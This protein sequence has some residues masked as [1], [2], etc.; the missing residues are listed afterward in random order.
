MSAS[1]IHFQNAVQVVGSVP[2]Q[3]LKLDVTRT[4]RVRL[5]YP[6]I[7]GASLSP[8]AWSS[9]TI[10]SLLQSYTAKNFPCL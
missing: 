9:S 3:R 6:V 4:S 5:R 8:A 1:G 2:P 7:H 10:L